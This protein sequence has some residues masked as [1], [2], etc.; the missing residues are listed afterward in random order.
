MYPAITGIW[1]YAAGAN[2]TVQVPP[3]STVLQIIAWSSGGSPTVT[4]FGGSAI[5]LPATSE[6]FVMRFNTD[7]VQ[8]RGAGAAAAIVFSSG[9]TGYFVEYCEPQGY[10]A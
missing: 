4:V 9:V 7:L 2:G 10:G 5:P 3:G 6:P 8:A 1:G